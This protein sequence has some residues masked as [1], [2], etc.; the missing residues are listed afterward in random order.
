VTPLQ[1][2]LEGPLQLRDVTIADN[3]FECGEFLR[4]QPARRGAAHPALGACMA[5]FT[6]V[7]RSGEGGFCTGYS[8]RV[9]YANSSCTGMVLRNNSYAAPPPVAAAV[10]AAA[11]VEA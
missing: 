2:Y 3:R 6:P 5:A 11:A 1:H 9:R 4:A 10:A 8:G 7:N